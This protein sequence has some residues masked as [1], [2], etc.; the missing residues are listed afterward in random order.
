MPYLAINLINKW[1]KTKTWLISDNSDMMYCV[2]QGLLMYL[3]VAFKASMS[4]PI[5]FYGPRLEDRYFGPLKTHACRLTP[6]T[7]RRRRQQRYII[8][9]FSLYV[10]CNRAL[11]RRLCS[12]H[13][14]WSA[15]RRFQR[16]RYSHGN[17][18]DEHHVRCLCC[19]RRPGTF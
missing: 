7:A 15:R 16:S 8:L 9:L 3:H 5:Y 10:E 13:I 6:W 12:F 1:I 19:S 4:W 11:C 14:H 18:M 2:F 17:P